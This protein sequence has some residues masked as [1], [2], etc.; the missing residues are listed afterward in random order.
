MGLFKE[1]FTGGII[2]YSV[3]YFL[4]LCT[5]LALKFGLQ[6]D[7]SKVPVISLNVWI[8]VLCFFIAVL[9]GLWP[10][11][12]IKST[13]QKIFYRI[14]LI[15]DVFLIYKGIT[16]GRR[17][18]LI[19]ALLGVFAML[20]LVGKH[21]GWTHSRITM[22]LLPSLFLL[23]AM[24]NISLRNLNLTSFDYAHL[25]YTDLSGLPLYIASFIGYGTHLY[26]DGILFGKRFKKRRAKNSKK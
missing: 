23:P 13:T 8:A 22:F 16:G 14:F 20:P 12:D 4:A 7:V 19:S 3:F 17:Y 25:D 2:S 18:L 15:L 21:R 1:H 6:W 10:D 9:S 5:S 24:Y 11:V 26:L